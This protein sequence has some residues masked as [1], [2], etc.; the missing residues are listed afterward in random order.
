MLPCR[1]SSPH[2][3]FLFP[4]I[5]FRVPASWTASKMTPSGTNYHTSNSLT[6][7]SV[8]TRLWKTKQ[9]RKRF[10][11]FRKSCML[12]TDRIEIHQSQPLVWPSELLYVMLTGCDWWIWI[13]SIDNMYDWRKFWKRFCGCFVFESH[14]SMKTVVIVLSYKTYQFTKNYLSLD[15]CCQHFLQISHFLFSEAFIVLKSFLVEKSEWWKKEKQI[16]KL[17]TTENILL[18]QVNSNIYQLTACEWMCVEDT[19]TGLYCSTAY[20]RF[21][22]CIKQQW[23]AWWQYAC[24]GL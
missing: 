14:V 4:C 23:Q 24:T 18:Q 19:D 13:R 16:R 15:V 21:A 11:N 8:D 5:V 22:A 9:P 7:V 17:H 10:Q 6:T 1:L 2:I 20:T 3:F 12:S